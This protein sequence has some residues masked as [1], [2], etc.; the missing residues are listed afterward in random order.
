MAC[1]AARAPD[2]RLAHQP[3]DVIAADVFALAAELVPHPRVPVALEVLLVHLPD[4]GREAL[5]LDPAGGAL[6]C[7]SLVVRGRRHA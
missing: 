1:P 2:A 5:V 6:A 7:G 3:G 4:P